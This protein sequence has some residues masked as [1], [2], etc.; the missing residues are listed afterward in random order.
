[1]LDST[2]GVVNFW[3]GNNDVLHIVHATIFL[4]NSHP[5]GRHESYDELYAAIAKRES[6]NCFQCSVVYRVV[7]VH[8][9]SPYAENLV[10]HP[11]HPR[12][13]GPVDDVQQFA[14][15]AQQEG[16]DL[17]T[18]HL[19]CTTYTYISAGCRC[20]DEHCQHRVLWIHNG[21]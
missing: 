8:L 7:L 12:F 13:L 1:M 4:H 6:V 3:M 9:A 16:Q 11:P 5:Q 21:K 20:W 19:F 14:F 15:S 17:I 18:E 2:D 10:Y